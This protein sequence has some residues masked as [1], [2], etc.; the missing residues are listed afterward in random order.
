MMDTSNDKI[1]RR[2]FIKAFFLGGFGMFVALFN[3]KSQSDKKKSINSNLPLD[4]IYRA[5]EEI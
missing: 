3:F 1:S 2:S 4:S 5:R